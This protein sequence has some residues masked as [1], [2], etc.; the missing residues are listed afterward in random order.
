[1]IETPNTR[2]HEA[3]LFSPRTGTKRWPRLGQ[4]D[5]L[6]SVSTHLKC[7]LWTQKWS[8]VILQPG[9]QTFWSSEAQKVSNQELR[10]S[11]LSRTGSPSRLHDTMQAIPLE[12]KTAIWSPPCPSSLINLGFAT[13]SLSSDLAFCQVPF[14]L[15]SQALHG[16]D[17]TVATSVI[18]WGRFLSALS[19]VH[20]VGHLLP[21]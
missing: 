18:G 9:A 12:G 20:P 21:N 8:N 13:F 17:V 1:M 19:P 16:V 4:S 14:L 11:G 6:C 2:E 15:P 10:P 3:A 5:F 7:F